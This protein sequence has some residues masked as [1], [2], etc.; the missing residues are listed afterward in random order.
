MLRAILTTWILAAAAFA[1]Q[2]V[3]GHVVNAVTGVDLPGARVSLFQSEGVAYSAITDS[4]G[5]FRIEAVRDGAYSAGYEARGFRAIPGFMDPGSQLEFRVTSAGGPLSLEARMQPLPK[6]SGRVLDAAGKPV[7]NAGIWVHGN[8]RGCGEPKCFALLKQVQTSEKGDYT[9][10][11]VDYA[12]PW[13]LSATAPSSLRAPDSAG[14]RPLGWAQTFYPGTADAQAGARLHLQPGSDLSN[15]DIKLAAVPVHRIRGRVLDEGGDPAPR[16]AVTLYNGFGPSLD[17]LTDQDGAFEFPAIPDGEWRLSAKRDRDRVTLWTAQPV[18]IQD[19]D[20]DN[21]ELR[22]T[23]PFSLH[24]TILFDRPEGVPAPEGDLA[25]VIAGYTAGKFG[26]DQT[27]PARPTDH[28]YGKGDFTIQLY[29]GPHHVDLIEP[30]PAQFYLDSIRLGGQDALTSDVTIL[31]D[32]QPLT[33]TYKFGGGSVQGAID[34]CGAGRVLLLPQD[35]ALRRHEFLREANCG[36]NGQFE[37]SAVRPGEY[38]G[39]AVSAD[40]SPLWYAALLDGSLL[41]RASRVT[42]RSNEHTNAEIR[43]SKW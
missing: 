6:L 35:P 38:Y 14:D 41:D 24:G 20:L 42:V 28:P 39:F 15:L 9:I 29:P 16:A 23:P 11:D 17:H 8:V 31:S 1:T 26:G 10:A 27:C 13:V 36:T 22:M 3:E 18:Q 33:V 7:A 12:G 43:L 5:R 19:R 21:V 25:T 30:P 32:A 37:F 4:E 40:S 34:G 2:S